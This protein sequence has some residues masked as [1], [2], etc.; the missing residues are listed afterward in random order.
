[1]TTPVWYP[2]VKTSYNALI[3]LSRA[4]CSL[5]LQNYD[6]VEENCGQVGLSSSSFVHII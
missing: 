3:S 5:K 4:A 1:M 6:E 2:V